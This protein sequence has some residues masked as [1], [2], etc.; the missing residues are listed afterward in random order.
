MNQT[1][2]VNA[3]RRWI[4][5]ACLLA[6]ATGP[7]PARADAGDWDALTFLVGDWVA[8]GPTEL[9][10]AQGAA[11]FAFELNHQIL[12]RRSFAEY[13]NGAAAGTRHDDLLII[14]RDGPAGGVRAMYFDS[15]GH[16]IHYGVTVPAPG[17]AILESDAAEA[18]PRYRL[19]YTLDGP[20]LRGTFEVAP[21][22]TAAYKTYL[23]WISTKR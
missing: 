5:M 4:V 19:S 6:L 18:G 14:Y 3:A 21:P 10:S 23:S 20:S 11:V 16:T 7:T 8:A 13:K 12:V 22:G 15:E 2:G 9:G 1:A 17:K